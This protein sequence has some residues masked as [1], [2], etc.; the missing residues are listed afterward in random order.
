MKSSLAFALALCC[1]CNTDSSA[2]HL[3]R[4]NV[5]INTGHREEALAE[6]REAARLAPRSAQARERL[7]DTL[8]DLG[9]QE[10]ALVAYREAVAVDEASVTARIGAARVLG[11][12]G[13]LSGARAELGTGLQHAPT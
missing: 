13:N 5:L 9:R 12:Q 7:G 6:Y 8:Y 2:P 11:D 1:A 4:G 3:A 10:E